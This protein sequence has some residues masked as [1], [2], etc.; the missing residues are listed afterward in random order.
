MEKSLG[1]DDISLIPNYFGHSIIYKKVS[2]F[3]NKWFYINK[4]INY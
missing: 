1:I 3:A 2:S 4:S